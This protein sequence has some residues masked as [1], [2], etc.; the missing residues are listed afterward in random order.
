MK[1]SQQDAVLM[2]PI[3]L[4]TESHL[5][6][7]FDQTEMGAGKLIVKIVKRIEHVENGRRYYEY[8]L[9]FSAILEK[10]RSIIKR[11]IR[12]QISNEI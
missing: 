10:D 4:A 7:T 3:P 2:T 8:T 12:C 6:I 11:Y 5:V 1:I 9:F